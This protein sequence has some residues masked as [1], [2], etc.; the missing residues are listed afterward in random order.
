LGAYPGK[1]KLLKEEVEK[2]KKKDKLNAGLK[3]KEDPT[4]GKG[5]EM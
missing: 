1:K 3:R 5:N 2:K 4:C